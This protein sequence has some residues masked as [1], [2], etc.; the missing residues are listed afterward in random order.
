MVWRS[1][2]VASWHVPARVLAPPESLFASPLQHLARVGLVSSA[3]PAHGGAPGGAHV[4][5]GLAS[6]LLI[7]YCKMSCSPAGRLA[8]GLVASSPG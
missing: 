7:A 4:Q 3:R 5:G 2:G 1:C 8:W 6:V